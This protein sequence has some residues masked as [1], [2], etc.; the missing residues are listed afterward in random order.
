MM[1]RSVG[2]YFSTDRPAN[3]ALD[4]LAMAYQ[5]GASPFLLV[6]TTQDADEDYGGMQIAGDIDVIHG[7]KTRVADL[8]FSADDFT[9]L[10]FQ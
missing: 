1:N 10:A 5:E 9:D 4:A 6:R 2:V 7:D 3:Q 8:E